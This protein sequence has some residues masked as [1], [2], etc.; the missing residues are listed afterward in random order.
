[1]KT[2]LISCLLLFALLP[3]SAQYKVVDSTNYHYNAPQMGDYITFRPLI[4]CSRLLSPDVAHLLTDY[5]IPVLKQNPE[6]K[7]Q[8]EYHTDCRATAEF[9]RDYSQR[10][11]D[12]LRAYIISQGIDSSQIIAKG[13]GEDDLLL[14]KCDCD[15]SDYKNKCTEYEHQLNRR[16]ILRIIGLVEEK[17]E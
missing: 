12:T 4:G 3:A 6:I 1:M 13:M 16:A 10:V 15:L 11:A 2:I 5:I 8:I 14:K 17:N 9:N 7:F